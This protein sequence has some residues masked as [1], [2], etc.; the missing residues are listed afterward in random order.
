MT[1]RTLKSTKVTSGQD[2]LFKAV[3]GKPG[4]APGFLE[5]CACLP[6]KVLHHADRSTLTIYPDHLQ[7]LVCGSG[8]SRAWCLSRL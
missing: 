4:T 7:G 6:A 5:T 3:N 2:V 1:G 8:R